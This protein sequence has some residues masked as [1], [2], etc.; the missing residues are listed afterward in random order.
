MSSISTTIDYPTSPARAPSS[1]SAT[2]A[3]FLAVVVNSKLLRGKIFFRT[4]FYFPSVTSSIARRLHL[5][6]PVQPGGRD[7]GLAFRAGTRNGGGGLVE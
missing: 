6:V 3:F 2:L 5:R 7:Q 4:A 1:R